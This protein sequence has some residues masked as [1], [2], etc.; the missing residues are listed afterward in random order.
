MSAESHD[1]QSGD[2]FG[3]PAL[4]EGESKELYSQLRAAVIKIIQPKD[5]FDWMMVDDQ[6]DKYWEEQRYKHGAAALIEGAYPEALENLMGPFCQMPDVPSQIASDYY[7]GDK[8]AKAAAVSRV[9]KRGITPQQIRARAMQMVGGGL[10]M[11]DRM[12]FNRE[13]GRRILRK[14]HQQRSATRDIGGAARGLDKP[15]SEIEI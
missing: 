11:M 14:E 12:R 3:E 13:T 7:G 9:A 2:L 6:T 1:N 5:A 4:I 8:K 15:K 10:Q